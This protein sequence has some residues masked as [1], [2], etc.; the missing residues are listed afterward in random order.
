MASLIVAPSLPSLFR[1]LFGDEVWV[2]IPT[3][4]ALFVFPAQPEVLQEASTELAERYKNDAYAASAEI[5][6][7]KPGEKPHVV[8]TF[9]E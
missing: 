7:L 4:N 6:A 1:E 5:F 9:S 2:A 8:G 3:R